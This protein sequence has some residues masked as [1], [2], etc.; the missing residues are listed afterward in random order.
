MKKKEE[1]SLF[2]SISENVTDSLMK[3]NWGVEHLDAM[4]LDEVLQRCKDEQWSRN[5]LKE[6]GGELN[7][8][9]PTYNAAVYHVLHDLCYKKYSLIS[10]V[11]LSLNLLGYGDT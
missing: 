8:K 5:I 7:D 4:F 2:F 3:F 10:V 6:L 11:S 1:N 9:Y